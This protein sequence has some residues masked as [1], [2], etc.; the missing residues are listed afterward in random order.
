MWFT[1]RFSLNLFSFRLFRHN[2]VFKDVY[3]E[4]GI[5]EVFVTC[6]TRYVHFLEK[7][8]VEDVSNYDVELKKSEDLTK[9]IYFVWT[10]L[11]TKSGFIGL[12][13]DF[14]KISPKSPK[15]Y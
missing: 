7:N 1:L 12:Y 6:L 3:R 14:F 15:K 5:L 9:G 2:I 10:F 11:T 8:V 4:V 13:L